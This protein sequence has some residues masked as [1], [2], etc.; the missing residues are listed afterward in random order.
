MLL[1]A[2]VAEPK[3]ANVNVIVPPAAAAVETFAIY[4]AVR[5][6]AQ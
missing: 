6:V 3:F 1:P 4:T 5:A 2:V